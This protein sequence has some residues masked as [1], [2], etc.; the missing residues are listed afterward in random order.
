MDALSTSGSNNANISSAK[1]ML[2]RNIFISLDPQ[3]SYTLMD[4][5]CRGSPQKT[6]QLFG[7]LIALVDDHFMEQ[8]RI[9]IRVNMPA[10][11]RMSSSSNINNN[12]DSTSF[13]SFKN[14]INL[15][16]SN[17]LKI[18]S[19]QSMESLLTS[20]LQVLAANI[21]QYCLNTSAS[22]LE[23][24]VGNNYNNN[25]SS[26]D[27]AQSGTYTGGRSLNESSSSSGSVRVTSYS[28]EL[29]QFATSIVSAVCKSHDKFTPHTYQ[30]L[31]VLYNETKALGAEFSVELIKRI[32][33]VKLVCPVLENLVPSSLSSPLTK[34]VYAQMSKIIEE[35]ILTK[36]VVATPVLSS[37]PGLRGLSGNLNNNSN[38]YN[39]GGSGGSGSNSNSYLNSATGSNASSTIR[40]DS[41]PI[42]N[43]ITEFIATLVSPMIRRTV[44]SANV[45][46]TLKSSVNK[47]E[48]LAYFIHYLKTESLMLD[49][50]FKRAKDMGPQGERNFYLYGIFKELLNGIK[51]I[52]MGIGLGGVMRSSLT[53]PG[54]STAHL[55]S[56]SS[57][58]HSHSSHSRGRSSTTLTDEAKSKREKESIEFK[59]WSSEDLKLLVNGRS[60]KRRC[61]ILE[62]SVKSKE[63]LTFNICL[64]DSVVIVRHIKVPLAATVKGLIARLLSDPEMADIQYNREVP[65][66]ELA[67][68]YAEKVTVIGNT[69]DA[70]NREVI[71]DV[72][73]PLWVYDVDAECTIVFRPEKK[74]RIAEFSIYLR[75][76]FPSL[77]SP[78]TPDAA[79]TRS[80]EPP[81]IIHVSL[82][83]APKVIINEMLLKHVV[84]LDPTRLGMY[85]YDLEESATTMQPFKLAADKVLACNKISTMDII[86]C[87]FR[88]AYELVAGIDGNNITTL[89][90]HDTP[91][92]VAANTL[93]ALI[94]NILSGSNKSP[95]AHPLRSPRSDMNPNHY[96]LMLAAQINHLPS[97]LLTGTKLSDY[98]MLVG[99]ELV[100]YPRQ[101]ISLVENLEPKKDNELRRSLNFFLKKEGEQQS[102]Q[103]ELS[104]IESDIIKYRFK[105]NWIGPR[106]ITEHG[107]SESNLNI[108]PLMLIGVPT[109]QAP[110]SSN[111]SPNSAQG[112]AN[113]GN[114][115][116]NLA[117]FEKRITVYLSNT[118]TLNPS[119]ISSSK[120][121]FCLNND[122]KLCFV[123][124]ETPEK[125]NLFN[126][127]KKSGI[128]RF[129]RPDASPSMMSGSMISGSSTLSGGSS[130]LQSL[131]SQ[132]GDGEDTG[133]KM[134]EWTFS[135]SEMPDYIITFRMHYFS[136]LEQYQS[137]HPLF[138]T[139]ESVFVI[140]YPSLALKEST[141]EYWMEIIQA[142]APGSIVIIV[143]LATEE[144]SKKT[145]FISRA[146]LSRYGNVLH[147]LQTNIKNPKQV[148][149]LIQCLHN[150][151][152]QKQFRK[153]VPIPFILLRNQCLE[154]CREAH[155]LSRIPMT[156]ISKIKAVAKLIGL[157]NRMVDEA[158]KYMLKSGDIL[159]YRQDGD[160]E[161]MTDIIFL[162]PAWMSRLLSSVFTLKHQNGY[163]MKGG[164]YQAWEDKYPNAIHASLTYLLEKFEIIH[165]S[166]EGDT[167]TSGESDSIIV[168]MLFSEERPSVM[169][170]LWPEHT[171]KIQNERVYHFRFLPKGFF[172]RLSVKMLQNFDAVCIWQGGMVIQPA[173]QVW[174]GAAKSEH[175]QAFIQ[176][177]AGKYMLRVVVRDTIKGTMLKNLVDIISSFIMWYFPDRL[178]KTY[179]TCTHCIE[180]RRGKESTTWTLDYCEKEASHGNDFVVCSGVHKVKLSDLAFEVTVHS[181]KFSIIPFEELKWPIKKLNLEED[182]T[183]T[184]KFREFRH[185]AEINGD[186]QHENVVSLKGVTLNPFC[187][188]TELLRFGDLSKFLRNTTESF[189]MGTILKLSMDIA[190]GMYFLHSRKPM[191]IHCDLKSANILIGGQSLDT[192]VAKVSDFGLSVRQ[193]DK[194]VKGRKVW[195]WRWLAPEVIK[196]V[197]YT[198]KIDIYSYG[199]V[200]WELITREIP[201]EEYFEE[202]KWNSVIEDK[203]THGLRP[204]IPKE[205]PEQFANLIQDCWQ[206]DP[207]RRP[208]FED[209][210]TQLQ[211]MQSTFPLNNKIEFRANGNMEGPSIDI[212]P[213]DM[214]PRQSATP[215]SISSVGSNASS[216]TLFSNLLSKFSPSTLEPIESPRRNHSNSSF[217][218]DSASSCDFNASLH[219]TPSVSSFMLDD[220]PLA[221]KEFLSSMLTSAI[222]TMLYVHQKQEPQVWCGCGDGSVTVFNA[223]TKEIISSYRSQEATRI[224]GI[225]QVRKS[226]GKVNPL[227]DDDL[228]VWAYYL[229]GILV[230]DPKQPLKPIKA[231]KTNYIASLFDDGKAVYSNCREKNV[232]SMKILSKTS[233]K[234]KKII[235]L[236]IPPESHISTMALIKVGNDLKCWIGTEKGTIYV[237]D[238]PTYQS[239]NTIVDGHNGT[240]HTIKRIDKYIW[241]SSEKTICIIN[242]QLAQKK[243]I[244]GITSKVMGLTLVDQYVYAPCWDSSILVYDKETFQCVYHLPKKHADPLSSIVGVRVSTF[245]TELWAASWDK[246][247]SVYT[248]SDADIGG[249]AIDAP[250]SPSS[251][252]HNFSGLGGSIT[253][254]GITSSRSISSGSLLVHSNSRKKI[255]NIFAN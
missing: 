112:G 143:G 174:A 5:F 145:Q 239:L 100:I 48:A 39:S 69:I 249:D 9:Y 225:A 205:C 37:S 78:A 194:E 140:T 14:I 191:I 97:T 106:Q 150:I 99:D 92:E 185:E 110:S 144:P 26:G 2:F 116:I 152:R 139:P 223:N 57:H 187:I 136:G 109:I 214:S 154:T 216:D 107:R 117:P 49:D 61:Q 95:N 142:K 165:L 23:S 195:N 211:Q 159:Y 16:V 6:S 68:R 82:Q 133:V 1:P 199:M 242:D 18:N 75:C 77:A 40:F 63:V 50:L 38:S 89:V 41:L 158:L 79:L 206:E 155:R 167:S 111:S 254:G 91:V 192:L 3:F 243:K 238:H 105:V 190:Q 54:E 184:E 47:D 230:F 43:Q 227:S 201:F 137:T 252:H 138:I 65:E 229:D 35:I 245:A 182:D 193:F 162:D 244:D 178:T 51:S 30:V 102:K 170:M 27:L 121:T 29:V 119:L 45:A 255:N 13:Q 208:S 210:I 153:K 103:E 247:I 98:P 151:A 215:N 175:G 189:T 204:T 94:Q 250:G 221:F 108:S 24:L 42:A 203:V 171:T 168:P 209:I 233:F 8:L 70:K 188:I 127:L 124:D 72:D 33:F 56:N 88:H 186:L 123:G 62:R 17:Y 122:V 55:R 222:H 87:N 134:S 148:R 60:Q 34:R 149:A 128:S 12:D 53:I 147:Y 226:K 146:L 224:I 213:I 113:A 104:T 59:K 232:T 160:N 240:I 125:L 81:V 58:G 31:Q 46:L 32:F 15:M 120:E 7:S 52:S 231:I 218:D 198:E 220:P 176:Y 22:S 21:Q 157:E 202:Y 93:L 163:L 212:T 228:Q 130:I 85:L 132:Q 235:P 236:K 86:E 96:S 66:Y 101:M 126:T 64:S 74:R 248:T 131:A 73:M 19:T 179:V 11:Q 219:S 253:A 180:S 173:G 197:Q 141:I 172:S 181:N 44:S 83:L 200:I 71:C 90:D 4:Y 183:S 114:N 164:I 76:F 237:Y 36:E 129:A 207:R 166:T 241:T 10:N 246:R 177:D 67:V 28:E 169:T 84:Q 20:Q 156:S 115:F 118:L 135:Q 196:N 234:C 217:G 25:S 251:G 161:F 80:K